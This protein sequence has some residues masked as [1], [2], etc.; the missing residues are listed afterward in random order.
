MT[1]SAKALPRISVETKAQYSDLVAVAVFSGIGLL[2]SL[3]IIILDQ[4]FPGE[5]F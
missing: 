1:V 2:L 5:W 4:S 3:L